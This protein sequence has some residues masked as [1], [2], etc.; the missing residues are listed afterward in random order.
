MPEQPAKREA[1]RI[2]SAPWSPGAPRWVGRYLLGPQLGLGGMGEVFEAWD[3]QLH[4]RVA[5][6]LLR[7]WAL[8]PTETMRFLREAQLQARL[9]HPAICPIYDAGIDGRQP[10]IVMRLIEGPVLA[11]ALLGPSEAARVMQQVADGIQA[12]H[13]KGLVHRD[14]KP[15]NILLERDKAGAW[16]PFVCDFGLARD[17]G[18]EV[19]LGG[20]GFMGT[21]S[22]MAPEQILGGARSAGPEADIFS[23]GATLY[24]VLLGRPPLRG[25]DLLA[26]PDQLLA[27]MPRP[28]S[29]RTDLPMDL[30]AI[31]LH[32]LE[33]RPEDRYTSASALAE[34]LGR[35]L[36]GEPLQAAGSPALV[37]VTRRWVRRHRAIAATVASAMAVILAAGFWSLHVTRRAQAQ[38]LLV[39]R[40]TQAASDLE[41]GLRL[42]QTM[43]PHDLRPALQRVRERMAQ[44]QRDAGSLGALAR[45]PALYALGRGHLALGEYPEALAALE[46]AWRIG[47]RTPDLAYALGKAHCEV[48]LDGEDEAERTSTL[49]AW[50]AKHLDPAQTA[51]GAAVGALYEPR[52]LGES[53]LARLRGD[54]D[55]ALAEAREA[56]RLQ[57][58]S[59]EART[60][61]AEALYAKAF[62]LQESGGYKAAEALY[63]QARRVSRQAVDLGRSDRSAYR[64]E[65][66]RCLARAA[67][68]DE[69]DLPSSQS[70][71]EAGRLCDRMLLLDPGDDAALRDKLTVIWRRG[72]LLVN[73][74]RNPTQITLRGLALASALPDVPPKRPAFHRNRAQLCTVLADWAYHQDRDPGPWVTEGL[75]D[76]PLDLEHVWLLHLGAYWRVDHGKSPEDLLARCFRILAAVPEV[77]RKY[78]YESAV[79]ETYRIRAAWETRKGRNPRDSFVL[80]REALDRAVQ[81]NPND[82]WSRIYRTKLYRDMAESPIRPDGAPRLPRVLQE[83]RVAVGVRPSFWETHRLLAEIALAMERGEPRGG[84]RAKDLL[85]V[86]RSELQ[87]ALRLNPIQPLGKSLRAR[88][89]REEH[90]QS[91]AVGAEGR[92]G[93]A[94][95]LHIGGLPQQ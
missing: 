85:R 51:F 10:Y 24:S 77:E 86:A 61:E 43:P 34:D 49:G 87:W 88:L 46:E 70:L 42:E 2:D 26:G 18:E 31:L 92:S 3:T 89:A 80:A 69:H 81:M 15:A 23:L 14:L 44:I 37:W 54:D 32:C 50:K 22:Y 19:S 1:I 28:R 55:L 63:L 94:S 66:N 72:F 74:G 68:D 79:G 76:R 12:A 8:E 20:T 75:K 27:N 5:L 38:A 78:Y 84:R 58:W 17:T 71:D 29:L 13:A 59:S 90:R 64:A 33:L 67:A 40:F 56:S 39:Q 25:A 6:K 62:R 4:R 9:V 47:P 21:P 30:E 52:Q 65:I 35:F 57:P 82:M 93:D 73:R 36:A 95:A 53:L 11:K 48:F 7:S 41:Q 91:A 16:L 45:G 83:A 60:A